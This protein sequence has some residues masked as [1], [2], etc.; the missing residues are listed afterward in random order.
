MGTRSK[1]IKDF[2]QKEQIK[3][4]SQLSKFIYEYNNYPKDKNF[5]EG[6]CSDY[7]SSVLYLCRL[8]DRG[9]VGKLK[10]FFTI[11]NEVVRIPTGGTS[12]IEVNITPD[13]N[14]TQTTTDTPFNFTQTS[15]ADE[16]KKETE[17]L[18][19]IKALE[20]M[21]KDKGIIQGIDRLFAPVDDT[22]WDIRNHPAYNFIHNAIKEDLDKTLL[23]NGTSTVSFVPQEYWKQYAD[24]IEKELQGDDK[25]AAERISQPI[26]LNKTIPEQ[27][28]DYNTSMAPDVNMYLQNY[29]NKKYGKLEDWQIE[30]IK[31]SNFPLLVKETAR[32]S[33][34]MD[35]G[36][37]LIIYHLP[38]SEPHHKEAA[39][40]VLKSRG[41][42]LEKSS[43]AP[44]EFDRTVGIKKDFTK[45]G[46]KHNSNKLPL[47]LVLTKQFPNAFKAISVSSCY[48]HHKYQDT[49]TNWD[50]F[51]YVPT[52][53][54]GYADAAIRHNL[55]KNSNDKESGLPHIFMKL[56]NV[57][58]ECELWIKEKNFDIDEFCENYLKD[59]QK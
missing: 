39:E 16:F 54:Q 50:N 48:G 18:S 45:T 44:T 10:E 28:R 17:D 52:G 34:K 11:D 5:F 3:T 31:N 58:A 21:L 29:K 40:I 9:K 22:S 37:L 35:S 24:K 8:F 12:Y 19:D 32:L 51:K 27:F 41:Y 33:E 55:D 1:Q 43:I 26:E 36:A 2:L 56:W 15:T 46:V 7:A 53:S 6:K 20:D 47:D 25:K 38:T 30:G 49:D 42:T 4:Y 14:W 13:K 23:E 59:L 57:A